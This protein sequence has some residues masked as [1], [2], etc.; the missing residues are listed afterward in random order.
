M[1]KIVGLVLVMI[2]IALLSG[3]KTPCNCGLG[4]VEVE[5]QALSEMQS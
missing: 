5:P 4:Q 1:K 2:S 3:C